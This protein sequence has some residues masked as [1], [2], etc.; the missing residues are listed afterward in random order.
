MKVLR[1]IFNRRVMA[2]LGLIALALIIWFLGP[3][4]AFANWRP[5]ESEI[6]RVILI[7]LVLLFYVGRWAWKMFKSKQK[8]AQLAEGL[9][10]EGAKP[11]AASSGAGFAGAG[12]QEVAV[13]RQRF[14]EAI[15]LLK[16]SKKKKSGKAATMF[17]GQFLYELPWY[18]FIGAPGSGKTTALVNSGLQF[19]L[20]ERFG[21]EAI[22]GVGG[23]RN[24]DWWFTDQAVLLDTAGRYTT[25]ESDR[26]ADSAAWTGF[27]KLLS[28]FRP[29]RPINGALVTLSVADLLQQSPAE[30]EAH[31]RALRTRIQEL[32]EQLNVRFPLYVL[33]SKTDLLPGFME[34]F[35]EYS[36]EER[37]QVWG[38]TFPLVDKEGNVL[39]EFN[40][41]F[42]ALEKRINDRLVDRVQQER[43]PQK[44]ARLYT[45]PQHLSALKEPLASFLNKVFAPS[46]FEQQ[47]MVRGVYFTSGTQEGSPIDRIMGGLARALRLERN[48]LAT[49]RPSGKSFFITR[50]FNDVIFEESGIAG[51]N[52]RWERRRGL[53]QWTS[54]AL[55]GVLAIGA[56]TAWAISYAQNKA[57][58]REV[59]GRLATVTE[60]AAA[61]RGG[62]SGDLVELLAPLRAVRQ[63]AAS[64]AAS[65]TNAP[66]SMSFGLYQGEKLDAAAD[67][68]YKRMLQDVFLP[69]VATRI[70]QRL[71]SGQQNIELLYEGLKAYL[72]LSDPKYFDGNALKAFVTAEWQSSLTRDVTVEQRNEL[73]GHLDQLLALGGVSLPVEPDRE[74]IA[75]ARDTIS[76][77]PIA[78]RI[79]NRLKHQGSGADLPEFT[80]AK[81]AGPS[82][83][84]VFVRA[85]G[86]PLTKG[87][88]GF[89]SYDGYHKVFSKA[90]E[91][92]TT[93]L[94]REEPWVLGLQQNVASRIADVTGRE[95]LMNA[96]R[97]LYLEEYARAWSG[98]VQ[99]IKLA[100]SAD[101]QQSIVISRVLSAPDSPLP[102]LLRAIVKEVTLGKEEGAKTDKSVVDQASDAIRKKRD[103]L[104]KMFGTTGDQASPGGPARPESIV[105]DQFAGLRR[106][107]RGAAPGQPAPIDATT[108][109]INEAYT[110]LVATQAA[111]N[112]GSPPPPSDI[113]NKIKAE[114]GRMPEPVQ[115]MLNTLS[116]NTTKQVAEKTR[117]NISQGLT[118][119]ITD[120]CKKAIDGR[121]PFVKASAQDVTRDDFSRLFAPGGLLDDFFQKNLAPY[122]DTSATPWKFRKVGDASIGEASASLVQFQR[123]ATIRD[124]F[125]RGAAVP[126]IKLD[127]KPISLDAS[128]TQLVI[129]VDGQ[130]LN[131]SHGPQV[132]MT[133]QWPGPKGTSQVRVQVTPPGATPGASNMLFEGPWAI[134]R[135]LDRAQLQPTKQ[136][137]KMLATFNMDGR[138]AQF[139]IISGSVQNPLG[140]RELEQFRCPGA[141]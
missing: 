70:E 61:L 20:A 47:P 35:G 1:L 49:Q 113:A 111:I 84:T 85:S 44:R 100:R 86:Q 129:D 10:A 46:R 123:A 83:A 16:E 52:L 13:L 72:M 127:F 30:T 37:E 17:G 81:A 38:T 5:L 108:G 45:F 31:A 122:V 18:M 26:D 117:S 68:A 140:L 141:L 56:I 32:H 6:A 105:D 73:E 120:F 24:C 58:L 62:R 80:I 139:E 41:R 57:Y 115:S 59:D 76:R 99:D 28:K 15:A 90:A 110:Q 119:S 54:F 93:Q 71:R 66:L 7:A 96:V 21:H 63:I 75:S 79:Y 121:Y 39:A 82:A 40:D 53:L 106:M 2:I 23:T 89:F 43:D 112:A 36:R 60:Q 65:G 92:V 135:M 132:P 50:L 77:I 64:S 133:M 11:A 138:R 124:V 97:R 136:P 98:F 126:S 102:T 114:S 9:V 48:L 74:L 104:A 107:V 131:Y 88:P 69:R 103:D 14:E 95:Q 51:T 118:S 8:D 29:R 42:A 128:I 55:V 101:L 12:A 78:Q 94:A 116:Q 33:V 67:A 91:Q 134:L 22:A 87:V 130:A 27:L 19:P 137:E 125:F 34:F 3:L 25:Q 109:L 4:L